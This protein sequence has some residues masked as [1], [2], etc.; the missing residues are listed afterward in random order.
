MVSFIEH[1]FPK[2]GNNA[3]KQ[4]RYLTNCLVKPR[5]I[6]I[7]QCA[8][9]LKQINGYLLLF[10]WPEN[11]M[12]N[13]GDLINILVSMS[14]KAWLVKMSEHDFDPAN[15]DFEKVLSQLIKWE[16]HEHLP[17]KNSNDSA[18]SD[19][20]DAEKGKGKGKGKGGQKE[21]RKKRKWKN[22]E[23]K[24]DGGEDP[25]CLLCTLFKGNAKSHSTKQCNKFPK[26]QK[27][28]QSGGPRKKFKSADKHELNAL[29]QKQVNKCLKKKKEK[30]EAAYALDGED[31]DAS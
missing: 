1:Y 13:E 29:V 6:S 15:Y 20:S 19:K 3:R 26:M 27:L 2:A 23:D 22:H 17:T 30:K 4:K 9:R 31:S 7:K 14:P 24:D 12:L 25:P 11:E 28:F 16:V 5:S 18:K 21:G 8:L 10:P